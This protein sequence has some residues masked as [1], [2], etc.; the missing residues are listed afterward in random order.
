MNIDPIYTAQ[1][2]QELTVA[3]EEAAYEQIQAAG[4]SA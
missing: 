4:K 3:K 2:Q 1:V